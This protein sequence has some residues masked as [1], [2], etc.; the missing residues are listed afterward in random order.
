MNHF[1]ISTDSCVDLFKSSL[2]ERNIYCIMLKRIVD[3][4]ETSELYDSESEYDR[5]YEEIKKGKLPTTTQLNSFELQEYF[6]SILAKEPHGDI[7][8]IPLSSGLSGTCD[9]AKAT[10][11]TLN[12]TLNGRKIY[13]VDSLIA[14]VGMAYLV[15]RLIEL[16]DSETATTEAVRRIEETRDHLQGWVIAGNL[17][18]LK[19]GGRISGFKAAVG[20]L[21][22]MKPI[23]ILSKMGRLAV[24]NTMK[25]NKKAIKYILG[26]VEKMGVHAVPDFFKNP[27]YL[28]RTSK[29]ELFDEMKRAFTEKYPQAV[30]KEYTVGPI[31]GT[32]L[33]DGCAIALFEG[34]PRL[35]I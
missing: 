34:A 19:R 31:I 5:F 6:E 10:A 1:I 30:I 29:N 17:F 20:T 16:R 13:V 33:G 22:N 3:G 2:A 7:I 18:H 28:A 35:D 14:T 8:H 27:I 21:L 24:E 12:K 32:H 9:N 26:N 23:I 25:G 4:K 11:D 15:E